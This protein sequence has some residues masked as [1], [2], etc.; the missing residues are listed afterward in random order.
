MSCLR[1]GNAF[2][3]EL[4]LAN[5]EFYKVKLS[6]FIRPTCVIRVQKK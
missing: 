4:N 6:V 3:I 2:T 1:M 5:P